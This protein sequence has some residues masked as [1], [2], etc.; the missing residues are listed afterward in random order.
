[1]KT[2]RR[3]M[4]RTISGIWFSFFLAAPAFAS[5]APGVYDGS[6][7]ELAARLVLQPDGHFLYA[8][9]YG[10]LDEQAQGR[11]VEKDGRLL[12]STEPRPKAPRFAVVRDTP[13]PDGSIHVAL[14]DPDLLLGSSLTIAVTY[15]GESAPVFVEADEDGRLPI[16]AGRI[17]AALVPDLPVYPVPL[18][19][20][21]LKPGGHHIVFRFEPND[22]GIADFNGEALAIEGKTLVLRRYDRII[23]FEKAE[24]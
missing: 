21:A 3:L 24:D 22:L 11:W 17:V 13:S 7:A 19:P 15:T 20:Y 14:D 4:P 10:A 1:M 23:T 5:V 6:Q 18:A 16:P 2:G 12:L 8:L 9:S